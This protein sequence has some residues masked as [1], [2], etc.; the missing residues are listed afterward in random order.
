[1]FLVLTGDRG[2]RTEAPA[3][4]EFEAQIGWVRQQ[5]DSGRIDCA[6]HGENH[7][8]AI[9]NAESREDLEKLYGTMPLV[10]LINR[11]VEALRSLFDQIQRVLESLRKYHLRKS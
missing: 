8:A 1:M 10:E 7:A 11:Q 4:Q 9:V 5:V 2:Y 3:S 6:Y